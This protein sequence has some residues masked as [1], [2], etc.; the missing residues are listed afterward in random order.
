MIFKIFFFLIITQL[1]VSCLNDETTDVSEKK[2]TTS[3]PSCHEE[4]SVA[5]DF[6]GKAF[7]DDV[8]KI[9]INGNP[10]WEGVYE[11]RIMDKD[12]IE[13]YN[14]TTEFKSLVAIQWDLIEIQDAKNLIRKTNKE[15]V[16]KNT[17]EMPDFPTNMKAF[18]DKYSLSIQ[19]EKEAYQDYK[20]MKLPIFFHF[21]GYESWRYVIYDSKLK[22]SVILF[23]GG[24]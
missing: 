15:G 16:W 13:L 8:L 3:L 5:Y 20:G 21:T 22:K 4:L 7:L 14:Y 18:H 6:K 9:S 17:A 10:C 1:S 19:V 23:S 2:A 11:I 24:V 12:G